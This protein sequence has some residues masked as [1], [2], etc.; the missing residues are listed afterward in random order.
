[1]LIK[2]FEKTKS[3]KEKFEQN[4]QSID[5]K[6]K[7][8]EKDANTS[9]EIYSFVEPS[10]TAMTEKYKQ[11]KKEYEA[12]AIAYNISKKSYDAE[13]AKYT[14]LKE[15]LKVM[16]SLKNPSQTIIGYIIR[17]LDIAKN[18]VDNLAKDFY[19]LEEKFKL[20]K[21]VF[22]QISQ[23]LTLSQVFR[24]TNVEF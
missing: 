21:S 23:S 17:D 24:V 2:D 14:D 1:M 22:E 3:N 13:Y 16:N 8:T 18:R 11:H 15:N 6:I 4:L 10:L 7:S 20:Q 5:E 19:P 12:A 9:K